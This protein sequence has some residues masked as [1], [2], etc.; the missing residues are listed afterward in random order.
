MFLKE[1]IRIFPKM[2]AAVSLLLQYLEE[3]EQAQK[4]SVSE[5]FQILGAQVKQVLRGLIAAKQWEN[6]CS[7][8]EQL[9]SLLPDDPEV[10]RMKQEILR[11]ETRKTE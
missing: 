7:V 2:S 11:Q 3:Q 1:A 8:M 10:L 5:E 6:A 4:N 9:I